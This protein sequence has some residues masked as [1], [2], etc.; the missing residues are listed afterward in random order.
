MLKKLDKLYNKILNECICNPQNLDLE[1][2]YWFAPKKPF[3][4]T[5]DMVLDKGYY[6][7]D[8][9]PYAGR[10]SDILSNDEIVY[11]IYGTY[12]DSYNGL[13][14][15]PI[16]VKYKLIPNEQYYVLIDD[17]TN[18]GKEKWKET[19]FKP[20]EVNDEVETEDGEGCAACAGGDGAAAGDGGAGITTNTVFGSGDSAGESIVHSQK[21]PNG[22]GIT[23]ADLKAMYT[24]S[25]NPRKKKVPVFKRVNIKKYM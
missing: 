15:F 20:I 14:S 9:C 7:D 22:P 2:G 25:L 18:L 11:E 17:G 3:Q 21:D 12:S 19:T 13:N 10:V 16:I 6:T 24:L 23:T 8:C 5:S 1:I 4:I